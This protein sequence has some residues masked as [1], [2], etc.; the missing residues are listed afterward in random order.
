[1][2]DTKESSMSRTPQ[3]RPITG[4]RDWETYAVVL[5]VPEQSYQIVL[6]IL[7]TGAG[8]VRMAEASVEPDGPDVPTTETRSVLPDHPANLS[9][10]E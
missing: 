1:M 6:G 5:D 9:F 2:R 4:T 8:Q 3:N 7:L 10:A